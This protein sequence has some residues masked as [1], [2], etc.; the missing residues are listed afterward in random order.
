MCEFCGA[1]AKEMKRRVEAGCAVL[2]RSGIEFDAGER[3]EIY[4]MRL[5]K[6]APKIID[7]ADEFT[8]FAIDAIEDD[9]GILPAE[10]AAEDDD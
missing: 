9:D 8:R 5:E 6:L 1:L 3:Y 2:A 4:R 10:N 7:M